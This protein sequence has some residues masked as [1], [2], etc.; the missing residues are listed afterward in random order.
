MKL[1]MGLMSQV[2]E[3]DH[4]YLGTYL[5]QS[6]L[7]QSKYTFACIIPLLPALVQLP[8]FLITT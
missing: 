7:N 5:A 1:S 6:L 8:I 3:E 4:V 2:S